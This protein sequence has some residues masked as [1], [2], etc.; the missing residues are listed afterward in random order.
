[1]LVAFDH[2]TCNYDTCNYDTWCTEHSTA[3]VVSESPADMH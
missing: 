3:D 1:M 2:D